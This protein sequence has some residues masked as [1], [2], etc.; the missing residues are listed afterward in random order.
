MACLLFAQQPWQKRRVLSTIM[1]RVSRNETL[2]RV[3][4][5]RQEAESDISQ[6]SLTWRLLFRAWRVSWLVRWAV[7]A[8]YCIRCWT[9]VR[10]GG[11]RGERGS[12][13]LCPSPPAARHII[14]NLH[15]QQLAVMLSLALVLGCPR[16]RP[17]RP[18]PEP[19][20][21]IL[22]LRTTKDQWP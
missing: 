19:S 1:R 13:T 10:M 12:C 16:T 17:S 22:S 7:P 20:S 14:S 4:R 8:V 9:V 11:A 15:L 21:K 2:R 18:S 5:N 3:W 6:G